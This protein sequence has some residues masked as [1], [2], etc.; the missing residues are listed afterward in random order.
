MPRRRRDKLEKPTDPATIVWRVAIYVRLSREDGNDE[1]L[2]IVNQKKIIHEFLETSFEGKYCVVDTYVDDGITGTSDDVRKDFQRMLRD[3]ERKKI[4]CIVCKT[5]SRAFRNYAD[6]GY[7]LEDYF[8]ARDVRFIAISNPKVDSYEDPLAA[9]EGLEVPIT[10]LMNDRFASKT[11]LDIRRTFHTKRR[12]GEFIGAFA[13]Y[14][15]RKDPQNKNHLI[16][17]EEVVPIVRKIFAWFLSG[18]SINE[19]AQKLNELGILCPTAYKKSKG[20]RYQNCHDR[21]GNPCW[22]ASTIRRML[23]N[24]MY[25]GDMV[26]GRYKIKSYKVHKQIQTP[27][28]EWFIVEGTHEPIIS[29]N[30][31]E[32]AQNI[33]R[34]DTR[35]SPKTGQ[36]CLWAGMLRC[37]DCGRA[38]HRCKVKSYIYYVCR[39]YKETLR[40]QCGKHTIRE[41]E[42]TQAV[43]VTLQQ[44]IALTLTDELVTPEI[45]ANREKIERGPIDRILKEKEANYRKILQYKQSLY[46]ALQDGD[47]DREEYHRLKKNYDED[48][49]QLEAERE[50][51]Q[52]ELKEE[53][54]E[55]TEEAL[56]NRFTR[57]TQLKELD[58]TLLLDLVDT[59]YI[60]RQKQITIVLKYRNA[61]RSYVERNVH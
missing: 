56:Q 57:Y 50:R 43:L 53:I 4:N 59:V 51:L 45:L 1:S 14:G 39:T 25:I 9:A 40:Q 58:R 38:M 47:I 55:E 54:T 32:S 3:I 49:M 18:A 46:Q 24:R 61:Y 21:F 42:L 60:H 28:N 10:G 13:P 2:S 17:D 16:L 52:L 31:F 37:A 23:T 15:Y 5:L 36:V 30:T 7:Y 22:N 12:N 33:L 44:Q 34:R 27:P 11:S 20:L 41:E 8:P 35:V 29:K 6:Q 48:I 19:V 26:Q